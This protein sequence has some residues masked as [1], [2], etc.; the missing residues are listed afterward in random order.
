MGDWTYTYSQNDEEVTLCHSGFP[1][2]KCTAPREA[3]GGNLCRPERF[4]KLQRACLEEEETNGTK[5]RGPARLIQK[6]SAATDKGGF[7]ERLQEA[8]VHE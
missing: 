6:T 4:R 1:G 8:V 3:G 2:R 5:K 7:R